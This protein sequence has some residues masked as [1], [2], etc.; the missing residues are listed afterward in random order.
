MNNLYSNY[1]DP[2]IGK[3]PGSEPEKYQ[4]AMST[5]DEYDASVYAHLADLLVSMRKWFAVQTTLDT[6]KLIAT[7][8]FV[9]ANI[10]VII[11]GIMGSI[12]FY[13][14]VKKSLQELKNMLP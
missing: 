12:T 2:P 8:L 14:E 7:G 4:E 1:Q 6:I 10:V 5:K 13:V 3:K 11:M 9:L